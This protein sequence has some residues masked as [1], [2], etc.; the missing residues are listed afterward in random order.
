MQ[1]DTHAPQVEVPF[2]VEVHLIVE[3]VVILSFIVLEEIK[4]LIERLRV[5][6]FMLL[7]EL[8]PVR[9][10][11]QHKHSVQLVGIVL[12]MEKNMYVLPDVSAELLRLGQML[13][14]KV[15]VVQVRQNLITIT[16]V[17]LL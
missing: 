3:L 5:L 2:Q 15:N 6:D 12:V 7:I 4:F 16:R 8:L 14:V 10:R 17:I 13:I 11:L 9:I 1:P